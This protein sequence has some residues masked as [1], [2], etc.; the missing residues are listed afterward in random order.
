MEIEKPPPTRSRTRSRAPT[1]RWRRISRYD[2]PAGWIRHVALNRFRD[3]FRHEQRG[4]QVRE[5]LA[6]DSPTTVDAPQLPDDA[7]MDA[8]ARLPQQQRIAVSLFYVEQLSVREIAV[9]MKLSEGAVK[10]HL[11]AGTRRAARMD[12]GGMNDDTRF[13]PVDDE[14]RRRFA[15]VGPSA[16]DPDAVLDTMR[17]RLQQARTRR[18][19]AF[20]GAAATVAV[21]VV[22]LSFALAGGGGGSVRTPPTTHSSVPLPDPSVVSTTP[23][24]IAPT[25]NGEVTSG[26]NGEG[27]FGSPESTAPNPGGSGTGSGDGASTTPTTAPPAAASRA[28]RRPVARSPWCS[29]TARSRWC[30]APPPPG[31]T[32]EI[33]DNGPTRVEV[34]FSN[35]QTE[36][37]IR[38]DVVDGVLQSEITQH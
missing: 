20:A 34:R 25:P 7:L 22:A 26:T 21:L 37:R 10:Y 5:R 18:R 31:Y 4:A 2:H 19:A 24:V 16:G 35:G 23:P 14:L 3:H 15:D 12:R 38:V 32:A 28:T 13:D 1:S 8:V 29:P 27:T 11:H 9:S 17:P 6:G 33:H 30:R 36:W